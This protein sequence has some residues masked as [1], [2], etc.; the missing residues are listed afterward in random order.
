MERMSSFFNF[1]VCVNVCF[2]SDGIFCS[3]LLAFLEFSFDFFSL[4][5]VASFGLD[6]VQPV[7]VGLKASLRAENGESSSKRSS[8]DT[9]GMDSNR[10]GSVKLEQ[11]VQKEAKCNSSP[12]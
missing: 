7:W 6:S 2:T 4:F 1:C 8:R 12:G 10:D 9:N 5:F 3:F 11:W